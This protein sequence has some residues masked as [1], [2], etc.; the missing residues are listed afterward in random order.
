MC[1]CV[2]PPSICIGCKIID[3]FL[4]SCVECR[5]YS[6]GHVLCGASEGFKH[7]LVDSC[8]GHEMYVTT[9]L[10][11]TL[12]LLSVKFVLVEF[13]LECKQSVHVCGFLFYLV[14]GFLTGKSYN[15]YNAESNS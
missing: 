15:H 13:S 9:S 8:C 14:Y 7:A 3:T 1:V 5:E 12:E 6:I 10:Y 4:E 2:C 11:I